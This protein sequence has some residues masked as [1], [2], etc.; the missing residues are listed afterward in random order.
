MWKLASNAYGVSCLDT[1]RCVKNRASRDIFEPDGMKVQRIQSMC[2]QTSRHSLSIFSLD[3]SCR[4]CRPI[5][6]HAT[7]SAQHDRE[8]PKLP[9]INVKLVSMCSYTI[10]LSLLR[11]YNLTKIV[12]RRRLNG[13]R[14]RP[15]CPV[16][17]LFVLQERISLP[18]LPF[19]D[20]SCAIFFHRVPKLRELERP[21]RAWCGCFDG[22]GSQMR[23]GWSHFLKSSVALHSRTGLS[24]RVSLWTMMEEQEDAT[25]SS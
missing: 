4:L 16:A 3:A 17:L 24:S 1:V 18:Y 10:S 14:N 8:R 23:S 25:L 7:C 20:I 19:S 9:G 11:N 22:R 13:P 6:K 5:S 15:D 12:T 21:M 2:E